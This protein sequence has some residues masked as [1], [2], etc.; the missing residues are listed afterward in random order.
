L[1]GRRFPLDEKGRR[2]IFWYGR[3]LGVELEERR[4]GVTQAGQ[5]LA[6]VID[7]K[8]PFDPVKRF[9]DK[10]VLV[11]C[12]AVGGH[13]HVL[14]PFGREPGM[15]IHAAAIENLLLGD[16]VRRAG[17]VWT[18]LAAALL[19][20]LVSMAFPGRGW[21]AAL[22]GSGAY[23]LLAGGHLG[24]SYVL[25]SQSQVWIDLVAPQVGAGLSL[26]ASLLAGY[27]IEGRQVRRFRSAFSRFLSP[28]VL[29]E[30]SKDFDNL[31][32]G[33]GRRCEVS[34]MFCD[35][36]NFTTMSERL[37]PEQVVEILGV[38]LEA[39][40][41]AIMSNGG[42]LSK[43]L[44]DGIMAFWGAPQEIPD[45]NERAARAA[46]AMVAAQEE[47][48]KR[49]AADGRPTFEIGIGL[50]AGPAVVG[51]V[52]SEKRLEYTAIGDTVNLAS[53][54]ESLTKEFKV[55]ICVTSDFARPLRG[56]FELK[57]LGSVTVKGRSAE[58]K[59]FELKGTVEESEER[60]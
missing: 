48:K 46:L 52:G 4:Y 1:G 2:I 16:S 60:T 50:H 44:G 27:L 37:E 56:K 51:T 38:Y 13:D 26:A 55:R 40:S 24:L 6:G 30:V 10:V 58:V 57:E 29:A 43:Y 31:R 17:G 45:H 22:R 21:Q 11:G 19:S 49:L 54:V 12:S 59:V 53:R 7:R 47:V 32:P 36:R 28:E 8:D 14:T 18:V 33:M 35:V 25:Y 15:Y 5:I 34:M 20:L 41:E 3:N 23:V 39:M 42:T 9:K